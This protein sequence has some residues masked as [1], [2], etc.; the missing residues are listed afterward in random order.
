MEEIDRV[1]NPRFW[2]DSKLFAIVVARRHFSLCSSRSNSSSSSSNSSSSSSSVVQSP[3]L[4]NRESKPSADAAAAAA[5]AADVAGDE[6]DAGV[7]L[8]ENSNSKGASI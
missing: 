3:A 7:F 4:P 1:T 6:K 5:T 8:R 2:D